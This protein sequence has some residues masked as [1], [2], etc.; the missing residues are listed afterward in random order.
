MVCAVIIGLVL[1][2]I[3]RFTVQVVKQMWARTEPSP[4]DQTNQFGVQRKAVSALPTLI[5][6]GRV[7]LSGFGSECTIC[8]SEFVAGERVRVLPKC[9]HGFH[10]DCVDR[11]LTDHSSCPMCRQC[12]FGKSQLMVGC[13][14]SVGAEIGSSQVV[15]LSVD[16]E[17]LMESCRVN[18]Y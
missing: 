12:S 4:I 15:S 6:S 8:L 2:A 1:N 5:Y 7:G 9:G 13:A 16:V 17:D 14:E 11:W 10:A 3:V 18:C